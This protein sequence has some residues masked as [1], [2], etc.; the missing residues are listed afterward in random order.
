MFEPWL[1]YIVAIGGGTGI[2]AG[3]KALVDT[4]LALRAGVSAREG[5]RRADIV[6]QRDEALRDVSVER[7]RASAEQIRADWAVDNAE[8]S[9]ANEQRAREHAAELRNRLM[10]EL[11]LTR[12]QLPP[13]PEMEKTIPR[14]K[15]IE[16]LEAQ[17]PPPTIG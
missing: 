15:L 6:Q 8:I 5:K 1:P 11:H 16:Q 10:D 13:W 9:R 4:I 7:R 12:D 14:S 17:P 3:L 2:G